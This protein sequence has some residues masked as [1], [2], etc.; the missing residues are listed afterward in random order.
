MIND[1]E[2]SPNT[3]FMLYLGLTLGVLL[4][5]WTYHHY[6]SRREKISIIEQE[7]VVCEYCHGAYLSDV[8]K[9]ISRC[10]HCQSYNK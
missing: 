5:I 7:L 3:A 10:P 8:G 1:V 6:T 2:L 4:G 9:E